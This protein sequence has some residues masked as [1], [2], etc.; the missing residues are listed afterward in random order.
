[1]KTKNMFKKLKYEKTMRLED[2]TLRYKVDGC[3]FIYL[4]CVNDE[5]QIRVKMDYLNP[6]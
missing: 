2:R 5:T 3:E 4:D 6:S 1:M